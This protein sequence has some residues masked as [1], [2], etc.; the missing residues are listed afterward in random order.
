MNWPRLVTLSEQV[1]KAW[2]T[3]SSYRGD[4]DRGRPCTGP[5]GRFKFFLFVQGVVLGGCSRRL[6][7]R[8]K[9]CSSGAFPVLQPD[10]VP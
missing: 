8:F 6:R 7:H 1:P 4:A 10:R 5:D 9:P 2:C 3:Y